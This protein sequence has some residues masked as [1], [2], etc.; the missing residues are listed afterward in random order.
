MSSRLVPRWQVALYKLTVAALAIS[1]MAQM[2]IF[3]RYYLADIP[4]LGWLAKYYVTHI[5]HY[6]A[7][8]VLL[9]FLFYVVTRYLRTWRRSHRLTALGWARGLVLLVLV[10]SGLL[11]VLKN[12]PD[13][14]F[15][16]TSVMLLDYVHLGTALLF[17]LLALAAALARRRSYLSA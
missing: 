3:K 5:V 13:V 14:F 6:I 4:G 15:G 12:R 10:G 17:G 11:C 16:P 8:L 2:P 9:L 7:A 1:G